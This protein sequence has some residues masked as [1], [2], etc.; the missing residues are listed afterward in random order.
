MGPDSQ[1][2]RLLHHSGNV[3]IPPS[4]FK[5]YMQKIHGKGFVELELGE[6]IVKALQVGLEPI[7]AVYLR[8]VVENG[9]RWCFRSWELRFRRKALVDL[10][11]A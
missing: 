2:L 10:L 9:K 3:K 5:E 1:G 4:E 8:A 7:V 11:I 6:W